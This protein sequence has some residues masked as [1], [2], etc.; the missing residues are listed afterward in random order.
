MI[1]SAIH[2]QI[3]DPGSDPPQDESAFFWVEWNEDDDQIPGMAEKVLKTG[4]LSVDYDAEEKLCVVWRDKRYPVI[5]TKSILTA[6]ADSPLTWAA[7][8][9]LPLSI[10]DALRWPSR[11]DRHTTL[12]VLDSALHPDYEIRY[13]R[14]SS[15]GDAPAFAPLS[16]ADWSALEAQHGVPAVEAAF[17]KLAGCPNLFTNAE[18]STS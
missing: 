4:S 10:S 6:V 1:P 2:K 17:S 5:L 16:A 18:S 8:A 14:G 15:S 11:G 12:L 13:V 3:Q 9:V 7:D